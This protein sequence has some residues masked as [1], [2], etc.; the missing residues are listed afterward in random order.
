MIFARMMNLF[1]LPL[2]K[3]GAKRAVSQETA[4][5]LMAE[6]SHR[7]TSGREVASTSASLPWTA[8]GETEHVPSYAFY[9]IV[10]FDGP[11]I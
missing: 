7:L 4:W 10:Q 11:C 3:Q 2:Q 6:Q 8:Y 9:D 5:L 1:I